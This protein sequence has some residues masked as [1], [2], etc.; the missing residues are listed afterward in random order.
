MLMKIK[1]ILIIYPQYKFFISRGKQ[2]HLPE[3]AII[4]PWQDRAII[5]TRQ[6]ESPLFLKRTMEN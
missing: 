2:R 6:N 5:H 4:S 3:T 1:D